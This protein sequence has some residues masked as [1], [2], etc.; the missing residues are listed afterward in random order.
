M[1][2]PERRHRASGAW[3]ALL[4]SFGVHALGLSM[5]AAALMPARVGDEAI[6]ASL[7]LRAES[8]VASAPMNV[9]SEPPPEASPQPLPE[10][11]AAAPPTVAPSNESMRPEL[12]APAMPPAADSSPTV[13][14]PSP[15]AVAAAPVDPPALPVAFVEAV[16]AADNPAP[17]YPY[18]ARRRGLEGDVVLLVAVSAQGTVDRAA[19]QKSSGHAVLDRAALEAVRQWRF[20]P[21]RHGSSAVP[22]DLTVPISF[23]LLAPP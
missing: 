19:V 1:S 3:V 12:S 7:R 17:R 2:A 11:V 18:S 8:P 23:R 10:L 22:Q 5:L 15:P 21:A 13:P 14:L 9:P 16:P 4:L 20:V 6:I